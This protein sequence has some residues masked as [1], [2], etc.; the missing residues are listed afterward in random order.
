MGF[1]AKFLESK[2]PSDYE[3]NIDA[4]ATEG[5][6]VIITVSSLMG[7]AT[8]LKAKQYPNIKFAIIDNAYAISGLRRW[9]GHR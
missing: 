8:A 9:R 5:Y 2:Q 3:M 6:N 7:D 1:Q 4:F